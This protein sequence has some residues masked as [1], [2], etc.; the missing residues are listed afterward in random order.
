MRAAFYQHE[1]ELAVGIVHS[2][3]KGHGVCLF[4]RELARIA[5]QKSEQKLVTLKAQLVHL[6]WPIMQKHVV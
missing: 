2:R 3:T 6:R 5:I 1:R 4:E